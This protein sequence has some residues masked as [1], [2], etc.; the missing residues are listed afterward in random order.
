MGRIGLSAQVVAWKATVEFQF[1]WY[2]CY[3]TLYYGTLREA[4]RKP[5]THGNPEL[6]LEP[7]WKPTGS[8]VLTGTQNCCGKHIGSLLE[9]YRKPSNLR[10]QKLLWESYGKPMRSL[11][12]SGNQNQC[13]NPNRILRETYRK[14]RGSLVRT[15]TQNCCGNPMGSLPEA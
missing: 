2:F 5:S 9:A 11:V 3:A 1:S 15:G 6:Q 14:P 12:L 7:Y 8:L 13:G 4:Y 10:N